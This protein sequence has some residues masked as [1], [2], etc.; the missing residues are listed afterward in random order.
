MPEDHLASDFLDAQTEVPMLIGILCLH[1]LKYALGAPFAKLPYRLASTQGMY[2]CFLSLGRKGLQRGK[3][4]SMQVLLL[5][6]SQN[7]TSRC[8]HPAL[9]H[10]VAK[11]SDSFS[12]PDL[13]LFLSPVL[14]QCKNINLK[15][16]MD[17]RENQIFSLSVYYKSYFQ[18]GL[19]F[20]SFFHLRK[21]ASFFFLY[22][23]L[24]FKIVAWKKKLWIIFFTL[25]NDFELYKWHQKEKNNNYF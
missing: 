22:S 9:G 5:L 4:W 12:G 23:N 8:M 14:M 18:H 11:A 20:V 2:W 17:L 7:V 21:M 15:Y 10:C 25:V 3:G 16:K 13:D 6:E 24:N 1:A 19:G